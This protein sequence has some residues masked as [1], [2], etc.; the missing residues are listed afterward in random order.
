M[1]SVGETLRGE[2]LRRNLSLEQ[3]SRETKITARLLDA[4]EKEQFDLLPG[5]VFAKSFVRQYARFLGLDEEELAAEVEKAINPSADLP[6][7]AAAPPE[8]VFKVPKVGEWPGTGRSNSSALPALALVVAVMLVCSAVYAWWQRSRRAA[9][10]PP[11][12]SA[13]EKVAAP[14]APKPAAP[15]PVTPAVVNDAGAPPKTEPAASAPETAAAPETPVAPVENANPAATLH[16][17]L[18]ADADTWVQAWA[19]GK[20]VVV[21]TLQPNAVKTVDAVDT[22]RIRTGNAGGLQVTVNGKPAGPIGPSGQIRIVEISRDKVQ[23]L[24]PPP[25]P[26]PAPAPAPEPL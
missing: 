8:P 13:V 21:G 15:A 1:G 23:I 20:C 7:F 6:S 17:S 24:L 3:I 5:G 9:P 26:A 25:K 12:A 10:A 22:V 19:D 16:V 4:I 11:P 2:R 14:A 18:A